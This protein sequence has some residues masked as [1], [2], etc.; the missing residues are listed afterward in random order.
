MPEF[1]CC[2]NQYGKDK[3]SSSQDLEKSFTACSC[4]TKNKEIKL[5][6]HRATLK[7]TNDAKKEVVICCVNPCMKMLKDRLRC[8]YIV[9]YEENNTRHVVYIEL[10]GSDVKHGCKQLLA[11][12]ER[13]SAIHAKHKKHC[14]LAVHRPPPGSRLQ[15]YAQEFAKRHIEFSIKSELSI[16]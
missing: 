15:K 16:K 4:G 3:S 12:V 10:K 2:D 9:Q 13:F 7:I 5:K 14:R 8:D 1:P 11:T 6:E